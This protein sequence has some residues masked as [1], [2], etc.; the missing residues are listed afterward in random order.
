MSEIALRIVGEREFELQ[1]AKEIIAD[2][3]EIEI[4]EVYDLIQ[5]HIVN[6][7]MTGLEF[8]LYTSARRPSLS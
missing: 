6:F 4:S 8:E 2:I 7:R 5:Q 1:A 3:F